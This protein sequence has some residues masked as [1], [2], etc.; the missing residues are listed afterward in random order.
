MACL[1][2]RLLFRLA[3]ISAAGCDDPVGQ[4]LEPAEA[5]RLQRV[6]AQPQ[7]RPCTHCAVTDLL[8]MRTP[9]ACAVDRP[10]VVEFQ[11]MSNPL[12]TCQIPEGGRTGVCSDPLA[13]APVGLG[14]TEDGNAIRLVFSKPLDPALNDVTMDAMGKRLQT[15][16]S[17]IASIEDSN[18]VPLMTAAYYDPTGA[19]MTFDALQAPFGPAIEIDL[20]QPLAP[21]TTYTIKLDA[22]RLVDRDGRA[23]ADAGGATLPPTY[24]LEFQTE[25][26][27]KLQSVTPNVAA[28]VDA[29]A[30]KPAIAPDNVIQLKFRRPVA[31]PMQAGST[32]VVTLTTGGTPVPI[33]VWRDQG[34]PGKC[35]SNPYQLDIV[36]V[37]A[38]GVPMPLDAGM[39]T[40]QIAGVVDAVYGNALPY[41][42]SFDFYVAGSPSAS[43]PN[44]VSKFYVPG[45]GACQ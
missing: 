30:M 24:T 31:D 22:A 20:L 9:P 14:G 25:A 39:Y 42:G 13:A 26:A 34:A 32:A 37:S 23:A 5:P 19:P 41:A 36:A 29:A 28:A 21:N 16:K 18:G 8:N 44:A 15:L 45:A 6:M 11:L 40:L 7:V 3:L 10:C 1:A 35:K 17:D 12:P 38:P 27:L 4:T 33:Q 2:R 43:D